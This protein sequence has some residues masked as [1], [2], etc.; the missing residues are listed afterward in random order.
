MFDLQ[1]HVD[2]AGKS[3]NIEIHARFHLIY[4]RNREIIL[5]NLPRTAT[6]QQKISKN[7]ILI[8]SWLATAQHDWG[9]KYDFRF[10]EILRFTYAS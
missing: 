5:E 4:Y 9:L 7:K 3:K 8:N 6:T 1:L 2:N 10:V